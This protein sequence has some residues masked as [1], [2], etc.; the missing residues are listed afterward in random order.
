MTAANVLQKN[1]YA[2]TGITKVVS[3][4]HTTLIN[5]LLHKYSP[6]KKYLFFVF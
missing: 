4:K 6:Q 3:S 5:K 1:K 2:I